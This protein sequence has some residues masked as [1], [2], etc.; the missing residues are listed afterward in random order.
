[1]VV[2]GASAAVVGGGSGRCGR[3]EEKRKRC[4][5]GKMRGRCRR[6]RGSM[7]G[8]AHAVAALRGELSLAERHF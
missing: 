8:R 3:E 4:E 5:R 2:E 6:G 7:G 1:V